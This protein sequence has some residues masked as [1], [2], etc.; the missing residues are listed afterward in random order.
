[1]KRF[2]AAAAVGYLLMGL[3]LVSYGAFLYT[4]LNVAEYYQGFMTFGAISA[5]VAILV[6]SVVSAYR[7]RKGSLSAGRV[8]VV[9][10]Y[11][12]F[13]LLVAALVAATAEALLGF[14]QYTRNAAVADSRTLTGSGNEVANDYY[15]AV[16][17]TCCV[18]QGFA[19]QSFPLCSNVSNTCGS[20]NDPSCACIIDA[21][22][23]DKFV[24]G[25]ITM[26]T[27][28]KMAGITLD[29]V[30][31][32]M[33]NLSFG[34]VQFVGN[35]TKGGCGAG[36]PKQFQQAASKFYSQYGFPAGITLSV[37]AGLLVIIFTAELV[38]YCKTRGSS[39]PHEAQLGQEHSKC[40]SV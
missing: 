20:G 25:I 16:Y 13:A 19:T 7:A 23:Y 26:K 32:T 11:A 6:L 12:L 14:N 17:T 8:W 5:G 24:N 3:L 40:A 18:G 30:G 38:Q 28:S 4:I 1:M 29:N 9:V 27:C 33:G 22:T 21:N 10:L 34:S 37:V 15:A 36:T 39:H 31:F 35:A 2:Q